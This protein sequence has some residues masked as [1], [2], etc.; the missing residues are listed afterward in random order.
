MSV[1]F[2]HIDLKACKARGI[3]VGFTPD[4][5]SEATAE[6]TIGLLLMTSRRMLEANRAVYNGDWGTWHPTWMCGK[7]IQNSIVGI[8]GLGRIGKSVASKLLP[9]NPAKILYAGRSKKDYADS[10]NAEFCQFD[11]LLALSDFVVVCCALNESTKKIF[12]ATAFSKM[13]TGAILINTS[14]GGLVD[15]DAL[16]EA[17]KSGKLFAAGLDVSDPEPMGPDEKLLK[18][19][20]FVMLPHI[21][22][23]TV[24]TR[25]RMATLTVENICAGLG[26]VPMPAQ[27]I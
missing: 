5:L 3:K 9:F 13:K 19:P 2:D 25:E 15:A 27:L 17:L 7:G 16:Y 21:G 14:R 23:A 26:C 6:L 10:V 11:D 22:S 20:N 1:G 12:D 18:L 4:V 24:E 8:L